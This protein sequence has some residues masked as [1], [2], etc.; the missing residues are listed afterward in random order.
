MALTPEE[1]ALLQA[2]LEKAM[3]AWNAL[4]TGTQAVEFTDQNGEKIRYNQTNST[5]LLAY[6]NWLREQLGL[7]PIGPTVAPPAGVIF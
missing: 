1:T 6:I 7:C 5:K 2:W 3:I 4:M